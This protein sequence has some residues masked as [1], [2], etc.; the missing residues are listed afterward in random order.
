MNIK[1]EKN[2]ESLPEKKT[3]DTENAIPSRV[4]SPKETE[5]GEP[6]EEQ[7]ESKVVEISHEEKK[8]VPFEEKPVPPAPTSSE[9]IP[10]IKPKVKRKPKRKPKPK[11]S[12]PP[13]KWESKWVE[14]DGE[15]V[16]FV[17][18]GFEIMTKNGWRPIME[19]ADKYTK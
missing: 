15:K 19:R 9:K 5:G 11:V 14:V 6:P 2:K 4:I 13:K 17:P 12:E 7:K 3:P 16:L 8:D 18:S 10:E 1:N